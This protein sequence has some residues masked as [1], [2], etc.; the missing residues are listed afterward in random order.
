MPDTTHAAK[1]T[2]EQK[3]AYHREAEARIQTLHYDRPQT[4]KVKDVS[5]LMRT[6]KVVAVVQVVK[7]GGENN[8]HYHTNAD[9]VYFVLSGAVRFYGVGDALIAEAGPQQGIFVPGGSRYWFE[10]AGAQDLEMLQLVFK[11]GPSER[12]NIDSHKPWMEEEMLKVY[13]APSD[14]APQ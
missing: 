11:S 12:I 6:D 5:W 2:P 13:E 4:D 1:M 3:E 7:D 8:L 14:S 9:Q 10:K